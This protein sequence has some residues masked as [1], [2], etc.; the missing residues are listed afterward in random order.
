MNYPSI[1]VVAGDDE[2]TRYILNRLE[3]TQNS[4]CRY[5]VD[6]RQSGGATSVICS[7]ND[8]NGCRSEK[9][10]GRYNALIQSI[11]AVLADYIINKYEWRLINRIININYCYFNSMEKKKIIKQVDGVLNNEDK[12]FINNL[13]RI[14]RRNIIIKS[15][16]DYFRTSNRIILEGFVNFRLKDYVRDLE[17]VVEKAV[18]NFLMEREYK[19]FICLLKYFVDIQEPK[20]K[21]IHVN[22]TDDGKYMLFDERRKEISGSC[23]QELLDEVSEGQISYDD[24]LVSSLITLAPKQIVIHR[25]DSFSNRELLDTIKNVFT[26][27]VKTCKA[28]SICVTCL[29]NSKNK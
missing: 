3:R 26:G 13:F 21:V 16:L 17:E 8:V 10:T 22:P 29:S 5:T 7:I 14:R 23:I 12:S 1:A 20:F 11:A 2:I 28:C 9:D 24:L 27:R 25:I 4:N 6:S 15:L 19:E 18:D